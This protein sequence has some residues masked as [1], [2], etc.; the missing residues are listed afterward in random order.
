MKSILYVGAT[1]MIG[2]SIYGFVDYKNSSHKNEFTK[3]YESQEEKI[4]VVREEKKATVEMPVIVTRKEV[5][6]KSPVKKE[7]FTPAKSGAKEFITLVE[8]D[9][10]IDTSVKNHELKENNSVKKIKT[11]KSKKLNHKLFSRGSLED[12]YVEKTLK[13]E[14]P[15]VKSEKSKTENKKQ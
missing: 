15:R 11:A 2:A 14:E 8:T 10:K 5:T 7:T 3:M 6:K 9:I 1:L 4:P 12:R 13:L